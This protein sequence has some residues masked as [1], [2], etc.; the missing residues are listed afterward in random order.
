MMAPASRRGAS[1]AEGLRR[2]RVAERRRLSRLLHDE[3]GPALCAAG[4]AAEM[5]RGTIP[6]PTREQQELLGR[7]ERALDAA[8]ETVRLL[9]QEASP[10]LAARRGVAGAL[11]TLARAFGAGL[12]IEGAPPDLPAE[13]A[14]ALCELVRD[15]LLAAGGG[16]AEITLSA[17]CARM[18]A[19]GLADA[20]VLAALEAAARAAGL[21]FLSQASP[22]AVIIEIHPG[23]TR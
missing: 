19:A 1:E 23:G 17:G 18:R 15:A 22:E 8:V 7:L 14:A 12:R 9:S 2:L 6:E 20:G 5:L 11:E 16:E 4:L 10:D 13:G 21:R 3:A